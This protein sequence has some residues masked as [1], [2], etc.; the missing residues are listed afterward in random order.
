M[1]AEREHTTAAAD[2]HDESSL[3]EHDANGASFRSRRGGQN[4]CHEQC[5]CCELKDSY[6]TL[7]HGVFPLRELLPG[8]ASGPTVHCARSI[9]K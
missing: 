2:A 5:Q 3:G 7:Y 6:S 9:A 1:A 4:R 8:R